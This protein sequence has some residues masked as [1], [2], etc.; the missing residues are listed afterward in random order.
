VDS[1]GN[2]HHAVGIGPTR[3]HHLPDIIGSCPAQFA[4][5]SGVDINDDGKSGPPI[6]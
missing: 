5:R 6:A 2:N 4:V 1:A 3:Q